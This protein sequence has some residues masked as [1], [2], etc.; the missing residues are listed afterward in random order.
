SL[1][2]T[3]DTAAQA[4]TAFSRR[5]AAYPWSRYTVMI[6]N[7]GLS[8]G[9]EYPSIVFLSPDLPSMITVHETAHQ[10]FYSLL[11]DNQGRNPGLDESRARWAAARLMDEVGAEA[12]TD[13][14]ADVRNHLGEPMTFWG[15][16]PFMPEVWDGLYLQGVK[17]FAS[18]G[19]DNRVD[20]ALQK[21]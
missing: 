11:G 21:Y 20:C 14:P 6:E 16:L 2:S 5:Y 13:I 3:L 15:P 9:E 18:L 10:W 19:D 1:Q 4:L 7:G 8:L 17:A 12:S